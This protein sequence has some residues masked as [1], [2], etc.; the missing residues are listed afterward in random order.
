MA[1]F[2]KELIPPF[3]Y[4]KLT[5]KG[6]KKKKV[7]NT[8]DEA[9]VDCTK[10]AYENDELIRVIFDKTKIYK[11]QLDKQEIISYDFRS[12]SMLAG[13]LMANN[14]GIVNVLD[15]GG[16]CG[17]HYMEVRKGLPASIKLN[18]IVVETPVMVSYG[19]KLSSN[20]LSFESDFLKAI[21]KLGTVD[22]LYTS[23]TIQCVDRPFDYLEMISSSQARYIFFNRL[24]LALG[25]R[26]LVLVHESMLS[27]NGVGLLPKGYTDKWIKYPFQF[28]RKLEFESV[29]NKKYKALFDVEDTSGI[30][31]VNDEKLEG[32]GILYQHK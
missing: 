19:Q 10:E 15:F 23:G 2:I 31:P 13:V 25:N 30:F 20:E 22:L 7:Y 26:N 12:T 17:A 28:I 11:S 29:M 18:W 8:Y 14:N 16:A 1:T 3:I 4:K 6:N 21:E 27:W 5:Q 32:K 9:L 24:G